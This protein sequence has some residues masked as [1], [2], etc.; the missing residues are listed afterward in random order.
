MKALCNFEND[1]K[2]A[3][4][5]RAILINRIF[6]TSKTIVANLSDASRPVTKLRIGT[7]SAG[8]THSL[9]RR[10]NLPT[11]SIVPRYGVAKD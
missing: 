7:A 10:T 6:S 5:K 8:D 2:Y 1:L 4:C 11:A 3:F 9:A